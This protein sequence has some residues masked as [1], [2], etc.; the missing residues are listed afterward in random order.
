MHF[1]VILSNYNGMTA[2]ICRRFI[3]TTAF[4]V[5]CANNQLLFKK[6][7]SCVAEITTDRHNLNKRH[8]L[9]AYTTLWLHGGCWSNITYTDQPVPHHPA[10]AAN[11]RDIA[12]MWITYIH[13]SVLRR[14]KHKQGNRWERDATWPVPVSNSPCPVSTC[15]CSIMWKLDVIHTLMLIHLHT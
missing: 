10:G 14:L 13:I 7:F 2:Y 8:A 11:A 6:Y 4:L 12:R 5:Y 1:S 15:V 3:P 9:E